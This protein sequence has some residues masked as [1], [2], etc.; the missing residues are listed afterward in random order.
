V[1][2]RNGSS[3]SSWWRTATVVDDAADKDDDCTHSAPWQNVDRLHPRRG[4]LSLE[5]YWRAAQAYFSSDEVA[6]M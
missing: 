5:R 3:I 6:G 1:H 2:G 4:R